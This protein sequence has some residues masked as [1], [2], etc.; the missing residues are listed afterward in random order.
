MA[1]DVATVAVENVLVV[2]ESMDVDLVQNITR[3][4]FAND[5]ELAAIHPMAALL[6]VESA[7]SG[8]PIP[9]HEGSMAYYR[10][11]GA[12]NEDR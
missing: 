8:S 6:S 3:A 5:T 7:V 4:L 2:H 9:F 1:T 12:W 11:R 10:E